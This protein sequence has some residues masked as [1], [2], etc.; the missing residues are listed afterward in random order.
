MLRS[1]NVESF[2]KFID[3]AVIDYTTAKEM[4]EK[5]TQATQDLLHRLELERLTTSEKNKI[6]TQLKYIRKDRRYWKDM[7][8]ELEPLANL[9]S[10]EGSASEHTQLGRRTQN[11]LREALGAMRKAERYHAERTYYP[12]V[13]KNENICSK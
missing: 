7:I 9:F 1:Y 3:Q 5:C 8:E 6:A 4:E 13:F 12:R 10:T 2:L 11:L